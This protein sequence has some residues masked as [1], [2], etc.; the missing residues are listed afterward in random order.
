[1]QALWNLSTRAASR[2]SALCMQTVRTFSAYP[3]YQSMAEN[4]PK[5]NPKVADECLDESEVITRIMH[6]L[7]RYNIYNLETFDWKK[8]FSEQG[9]D[10]LEAT[11]LI[12]SI[13][14]EFNT[15]FEDRVF[16]NFE[17]LD[18]IKRQIVLDHN[19]F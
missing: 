14:Q 19:A 15:I 6:V 17:N 5:K 4:I 10:S 3:W 11:A 2:R 9:V 13:E 8:S 12:T 18:Q 1:M 16:E 7:H